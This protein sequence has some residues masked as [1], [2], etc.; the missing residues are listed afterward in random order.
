MIYN[1]HSVNGR[2]E[3]H[4]ILSVLHVNQILQSWD[5]GELKSR[6]GWELQR[7]V[8]QDSQTVVAAA[9]ILTR[10]NTVWNKG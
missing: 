3:W 5:W 10:R 8:W 9:Q 7:I 2:E 1:T 4:S 6:Y